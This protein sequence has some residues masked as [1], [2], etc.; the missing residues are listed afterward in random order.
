MGIPTFA[1]RITEQDEN[2]PHNCTLAKQLFS[3]LMKHLDISCRLCSVVSVGLGQIRLERLQ[4]CLCSLSNVLGTSRGNF[5][6]V[7][8]GGLLRVV[9]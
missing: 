8:L 7:G 2:T 6:G 3:R 5:G 9:C 1:A 4:E